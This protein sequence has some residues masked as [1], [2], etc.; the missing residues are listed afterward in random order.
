MTCRLF[1]VPVL[2]LAACAQQAPAPSVVPAPQPHPIVELP[3]EPVAA[4]TGFELA[5]TKQPPAEASD[6]DALLV[7]SAMSY[8]GKTVARFDGTSMELIEYDR[9][10]LLDEA[11]AD[12]QFCA[13]ASAADVEPRDGV[14]TVDEASTLEASVLAQL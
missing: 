6:A 8:L 7:A 12:P 11:F 3:S 14:L 13:L 1:V 9:A 5:S 4:C 2:L 10:E